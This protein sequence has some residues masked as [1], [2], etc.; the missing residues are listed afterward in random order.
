MAIKLAKKSAKESLRLNIYN[1]CGYIAIYASLWILA[2]VSVL[3]QILASFQRNSAQA[4]M[5]SNSLRCHI[6]HVDL[7][8]NESAIKQH[9]SSHYLDYRPYDCITCTKK[10]RTFK[11][12]THDDMSDHIAESHK[13]TNYS[14]HVDI[15]QEGEAKLKL[16][17]D[18]CLQFSELIF[19]SSVALHSNSVA[20]EPDGSAGN[21]L[22]PSRAM[23]DTENGATEHGITSGSTTESKEE[24]GEFEVPVTENN[25]NVE[26]TNEGLLYE[27]YSFRSD[28]LTPNLTSYGS[29]EEIKP[30]I[31]PVF[32][33]GPT[34]IVVIDQTMIDPVLNHESS[35]T[36]SAIVSIKPEPSVSSVAVVLPLRAALSFIDPIDVDTDLTEN[37]SFRCDV[38][39]PNANLQDNAQDQQN[40]VTQKTFAKPI[41][42]RKK[43][44]HPDINTNQ[45]AVKR[46]PTDPGDS[47]YNLRKRFSLTNT[48][49][50]LP[51][52][53]NQIQCRKRPAAASQQE[54]P[55]QTKKLIP[56]K[57]KNLVLNFYDVL[58]KYPSEL[59][60][61][62]KKV[63]NYLKTAGRNIDEKET[64]MA[65]K[66][67][68]NFI[69]TLD[70]NAMNEHFL[71][72]IGNHM[73]K[74]VTSDSEPLS[75]CTELWILCYKLAKYQEG[76]LTKDR[77]VQFY[78][79]S[80]S[81]VEGIYSMPTKALTVLYKAHE[82]LG[83]A[84]KCQKNNGSFLRFMLDE[85]VAVMS[86]PEVIS[87][88]DSNDSYSILIQNV[89]REIYQIIYCAFGNSK[90]EALQNMCKNH[91]SKLKWKPDWALAKKML[92]VLL[93]RKL[94]DLYVQ[95]KPST[96]MVEVISRIFKFVLRLDVKMVDAFR[97][98]CRNPPSLELK[99]VTDADGLTVSY[100]EE[101]ST[102]DGRDPRSALSENIDSALQNDESSKQC[103]SISAKCLYLICLSHYRNDTWDDE[104]HRMIRSCLA[105]SVPFL[106]D[107]IQASAWML[108]ANYS[109]LTLPDDELQEKTEEF[110]FP[111]KLAIYL[112]NY[113]NGYFSGNAHLDIA[114][115]MYQIRTRLERLASKDST[116]KTLVEACKR[117]T[118]GM[119]LKCRVHFE[120]ARKYNDTTSEVPWM[121][122]YFL[123]KIAAKLGDP[124]EKVM[125][126][127][128]QSAIAMEKE[129]Y[130]YPQEIDRTKQTNLEPLEIY[131]KVHS[132]ALK[133]LTTYKAKQART[134]GSLIAYV[135]H[136]TKVHAFLEQFSHYGVATGT[137]KSDQR[138]YEELQMSLSNSCSDQCD[139][140][141]E[142]DFYL[143][144]H[145]TVHQ[146]VSV[147]DLHGKIAAMCS[148]AFETILVKFPHY[149]ACYRLAKMFHEAGEN[150]KCSDTLFDRLLF[151]TNKKTGTTSSSS[152]FKNITYILSN[153]FERSGSWPYHVYNIVHL[154]ITVCIKT[155][156]LN[157]LVAIEHSLISSPK[158]EESEPENVC[159]KHCPEMEEMI[160]K[161]KNRRC[162]LLACK[163]KALYRRHQVL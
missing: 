142:N 103:L 69:T 110:L 26:R 15:D 50:T 2:G 61:E 3:Q 49:D 40:S 79:S 133:Q 74:L 122:P 138:F 125:D 43:R 85:F 89:E 119:L 66:K 25:G 154:A 75:N 91:R 39:N 47:A 19:R 24:I 148:T 132:Y 129:G 90:C 126:L 8:D 32:S 100:L 27:N 107:R 6:C 113:F 41:R 31:P 11:T 18:E 16:A 63:H 147:T 144:V 7:A 73:K 95:D 12:T 109:Y 22:F 114:V 68:L 106:E 94:P 139:K 77:L 121:S 65:L 13:G 111:Y 28:E 56:I 21:A 102:A 80:E 116:D 143:D 82:V 160:T 149:K 120:F 157:R 10:G 153:A 97:D 112:K 71:N 17:I 55:Q 130:S 156:E 5:A 128:H 52:P 57:P 45:S 115:V 4:E 76:E 163:N 155:K 23:T 101:Y 86:N 131:Y 14:Y 33:T 99:Q 104:V 9:I 135:T 60:D 151:P 96:E 1:P 105:I 87:A 108:L 36:P 72:N 37:D 98:F 54:S 44:N 146:M 124:V 42:S 58:V 83:G 150:K 30:S 159:E 29:A 81:M 161:Y 93:Q 145:N 53:S 158:S 34:A 117:K 84:H 123:A 59:R 134:L 46:K 48:N 141:P 137:G 162:Q 35:T 152:F 64:E 62:I 51:G 67:C 92:R 88:I 78:E 127:Y 118:N 140:V 70:F 20:G 38:S 136:L